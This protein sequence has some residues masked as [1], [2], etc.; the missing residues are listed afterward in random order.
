MAFRK[1]MLEKDENKCKAAQRE[2]YKEVG[3]KPK[4]MNFDFEG[5]KLLI[6]LP[7]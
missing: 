5:S 3:L 1:G 7:G 2:V 4:I 6:K